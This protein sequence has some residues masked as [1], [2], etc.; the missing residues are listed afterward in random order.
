MSDPL[1]DVEDL[2]AAYVSGVN[3]LQ[4]LSLAVERGSVTLVIG[5]NGAGKTLRPDQAAP[6]L[7]PLC[8]CADQ[9]S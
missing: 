9:Q 3:I 1:L 5:P 2:H 4:G 8:W 7:H 6:W